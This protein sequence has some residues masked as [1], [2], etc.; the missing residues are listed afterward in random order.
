MNKSYQLTKCS[1]DYWSYDKTPFYNSKQVSI[2]KTK[3]GD[4]IAHVVKKDGKKE[5]LVSK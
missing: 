4:I 3:D 5:I 2:S 1:D